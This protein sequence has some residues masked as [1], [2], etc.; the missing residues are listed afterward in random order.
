MSKTLPNMLETTMTK[1]R[2]MVDANSVVGDP[3]TT[4]DGMTIIPISKVAVGYGGGGSDY[5]SKNANKYE[6]PFGGGAAAGVTVTPVAFMVIKDG[7]VRLLSVAKPVSTTADR[8]VELVPELLD[9][10]GEFLDA[11]EE[12]EG[13]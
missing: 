7:N 8:I 5:V 2:E 10:L 3:I 4:V 9:R 13:E 1:L 12:K 11:R 6:N